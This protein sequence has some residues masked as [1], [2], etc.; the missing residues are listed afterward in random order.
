MQGNSL[1]RSTKVEVD[2][3]RCIPYKGYTQKLEITY[4]FMC[5]QFVQKRE[6]ID[7]SEE[8]K[9]QFESVYETDNL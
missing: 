4:E 1:I 6:I 2:N 7:G 8:I 5:N 3:D 9:K